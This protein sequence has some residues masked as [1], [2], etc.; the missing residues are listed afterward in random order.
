MGYSFAG[1]VAGDVADQAAYSAGDKMRFG[2][3]EREAAAVA[4]FERVAG[5]FVWDEAQT[6]WIHQSV[7]PA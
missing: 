3:K 6:R 7:V 2:K 5:Q 1:R 4:A